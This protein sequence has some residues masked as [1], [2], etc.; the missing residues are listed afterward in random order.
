MPQSLYFPCRLSQ[1]LPELLADARRMGLRT[2]AVL[3]AGSLVFRAHHARAQLS[4]SLSACRGP[5]LHAWAE[6]AAAVVYA[7]SKVP[8]RARAK[9]Q[10]KNSLTLAL[11]PCRYMAWA[12]VLVFIYFLLLLCIHV[13]STR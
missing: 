13:V 4:A 9:L 1:E 8:H 10:A 5:G 12:L 7:K 6:L 11:G 2:R 3:R